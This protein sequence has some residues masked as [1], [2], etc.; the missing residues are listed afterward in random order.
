MSMRL[1][2]LLA[3]SGFVLVGLVIAGV[4]TY[5]LLRSFLLDRV[6]AQLYAAQGPVVTALRTGGMPSPGQPPNS[7]TDE[8]LPPGTMGEALRDGRLLAQP[9][10]LFD[11][12]QTHAPRPAL[13]SPLGA[14]PDG[15]ISQPAPR[16]RR[17]STI[18][19]SRGSFRSPERC[20]SSA[21]RSPTSATF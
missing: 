5:V 11:Q 9:V 7:G 16:G 12:G 19:S 8:L 4:A 6:D 3:I 20:S 15:R 17:R 10:W 13:P 2:L 21:S 18:A 14:T 1:R